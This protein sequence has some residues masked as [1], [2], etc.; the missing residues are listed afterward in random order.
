MCRPGEAGNT[1]LQAVTPVPLGH[2]ALPATA[3]SS[4]LYCSQIGGQMALPPPT[5]LLPGGRGV[6]RQRSWGP[7]A[8]SP[9][10]VQLGRA[11]PPGGWKDSGRSSGGGGRRRE[12]G[13]WVGV[14]TSNPSRQPS[15]ACLSPYHTLIVC[16]FIYSLCTQG[17]LSSSGFRAYVKDPEGTGPRYLPSADVL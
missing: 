12:G 8:T 7:S 17:P 14:S 6:R 16:A 9:N 11:E 1:P 5:P 13:P 10:P 2:V 4:V 15:A 3:L